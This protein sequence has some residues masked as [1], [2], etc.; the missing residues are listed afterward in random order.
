MSKP[1]LNIEYTLGCNM[2]RPRRHY[3]DINGEQNFEE[4]GLIN[5][6][7]VVEKLLLL[8]ETEVISSQA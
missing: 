5:H 2:T 4:T 7:P 3:F 8:Q 6:T 1:S